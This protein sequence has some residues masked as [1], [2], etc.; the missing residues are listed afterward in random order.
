MPS[1]SSP[2]CR[3]FAGCPQPGR[4]QPCRGCGDDRARPLVIR[5]FSDCGLRLSELADL[6]TDDILRSGRQVRLQIRGKGARQRRVPV[7]PFLLCRL[8]RHCTGRPADRR[9]DHLFPVDAAWSPRCA[10]TAHQHQHWAARRRRWSAG[11]VGTTGASE[12]APPLVDDRD[13][14]PRDEPDP[15]LGGRGS[16]AVGDRPAL[17]APH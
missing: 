3:G 4:D 2:S 13:A 12:P 6:R 15:A 9:S 5:L 7:P 11:R 1:L 16:S 8:D 10:R 14:V 17:R